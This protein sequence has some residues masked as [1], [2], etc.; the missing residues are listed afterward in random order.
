MPLKF[1]KIYPKPRHIFF[2]L[3]IYRLLQIFNGRIYVK[4]IRIN[5]YEY[6]AIDNI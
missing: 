5:L 1:H 3:V 6:I 2:K 4:E